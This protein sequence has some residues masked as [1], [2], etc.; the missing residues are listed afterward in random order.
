M[1]TRIVQ[2]RFESDDLATNADTTGTDMGTAGDTLKQY[3]DDVE[4][5]VAEAFELVRPLIEQTIA[6]ANTTFTTLEG[7]YA[8][9]TNEGAFTTAA[10]TAVSDGRVAFEQVLAAAAEDEAATEASVV[11]IIADYVSRTV[12]NVQAPAQAVNESLTALGTMVSTQQAGHEEV[13]A[14]SAGRLGTA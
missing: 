12:T 1:T 4:A 5:K 2:D 11:Q 7:R 13:D 9:S 6:D 14:T 3:T 10:A 8:D